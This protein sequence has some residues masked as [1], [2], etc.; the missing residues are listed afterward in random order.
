MKLFYPTAAFLLFASFVLA[1]SPTPGNSRLINTSQETNFRA[2]TVP[3]ISVS[4]HGAVS[5][6][7][8]IARLSFSV[9]T[10]EADIGE[11]VSKNN[12]SVRNILEEL[13]ANGIPGAAITTKS[14]GVNRREIRE[15]GVERATVPPKVVFEAS[16]SIEIFVEDLDAVGATIEGLIQ[17]GVSKF[18]GP[19]YA[20]AN[21]QPDMDAARK[22]A[23]A[24]AR[25]KAVLYAQAAG[26]Q[27]GALLEITEFVAQPPRTQGLL[28]V[29]QASLNNGVPL[30]P[31]KVT[32]RAE[33]KLVFEL[34]P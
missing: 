7:P 34:L 3:T 11:A 12:T 20:I 32:T 2:D 29:T 27:V 4:G 14:F 33:I 30:A 23:V 18:R 22:A 10:S 5:S 21:R 8:D 9:E 1:Q 17:S 28:E 6:V 26:H 15:R 31:S 16:N 25:A 19:S 24:D 13:M